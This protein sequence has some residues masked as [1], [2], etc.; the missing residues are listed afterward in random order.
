MPGQYGP[1]G[2]EEGGDKP[3][4][5]SAG[6]GGSVDCAR[7]GGISSGR[8]RVLRS[9]TRGSAQ[10]VCAFTVVL[11]DVQRRIAQGHSFTARSGM[12]E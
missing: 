12:P 1:E 10:R 4:G 11:A 7:F 3:I 9:Q 5:A 8:V 2:Y 6:S